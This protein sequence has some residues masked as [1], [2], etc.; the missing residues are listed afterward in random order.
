MKKKLLLTKIASVVILTLSVT[1]C[2]RFEKR[3]QAEGDF[4]YVNSTLTNHYN[5]GNFTQDEIR[6]VF[7]IQ[8]LTEQQKAFGLLAENVDIRPPIQLMPVIEGVQLDPEEIN[9][10]VWF[11][12][13]S[14]DDKMEQKVWDLTIKYLAANN[15]EKVK[16]DRQKLVIYTGPVIQTRSYGRNDIVEQA[17]Y[18]LEF[19]KA[20]DGRSVSMMID[21]KNHQLLNNDFKVKEILQARTKHNIEVNFINDLLRFAY[22]E[23][24]SEKKVANKI[25]NL[26]MLGISYLTCLR[27]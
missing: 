24:E 12:A 22:Q 20:E 3:A 9:T 10:K 4:D 1:S 7:Q 18:M 5:A 21:V 2:A 19:S 26:L 14:H 6:S 11:N 25:P 17:S 8:P 15:A 23:K 27:Q 16:A 13:F